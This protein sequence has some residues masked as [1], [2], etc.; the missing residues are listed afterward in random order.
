MQLRDLTAALIGLIP[1]LLISIVMGL[2][3]K[4]SGP[5][6]LLLT[7][8]LPNLLLCV[9]LATVVIRRP[10]LRELKLAIGL[11]LTA[12]VGAIGLLTWLQ[13]RIA[14]TE[15]IALEIGGKALVMGLPAVWLWWL[16]RDQSRA[17]HEPGFFG[18]AAFLLGF[19]PIFFVAALISFTFKLIGI[20]AQSNTKEISDLLAH[21]QL[22]LAILPF[23]IAVLAPMYE[24]FFF[25]YLIFGTLRKHVDFPVAAVTSAMV[26]G[27][28]HGMP[29]LIPV[30]ALLGVVMAWV[31][32]RTGSIWA[33]ILFHVSWNGVN[34]VLA[35]SL[36][37]L[38]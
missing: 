18:V 21:D 17:F 1:L 30:T 15:L 4:L 6:T 37:D 16:D 36:H 35:R 34:L 31:Y 23:F 29:L 13:P 3:N 38:T 14:A 8:F 24:E 28:A 25:R 26:F 19:V 20:D 7:L 5:N 32:E 27:L 33:A 22:A 9:I 11:Y 2:L 12:Q 10:E